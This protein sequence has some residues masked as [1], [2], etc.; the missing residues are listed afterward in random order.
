MT[1]FPWKE[2]KFGAPDAHV[3]TR[4]GNYKL[5]SNASFTTAPVGMFAVMSA[6]NTSLANLNGGNSSSWQTSNLKT[7]RVRYDGWFYVTAA[8][9]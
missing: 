5:S 7:S 4:C 1:T 9:S 6:A 2:I 8:Q 3:A